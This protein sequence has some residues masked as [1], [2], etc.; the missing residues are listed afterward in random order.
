M[1]FYDLH[2][3]LCSIFPDLNRCHRKKVA[4]KTIDVESPL[5]L[6]I[7]FAFTADLNRIKTSEN[8]V[9]KIKMK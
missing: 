1:R 4:E 2:S 8:R 9:Q 3:V 5:L 7:T 6:V